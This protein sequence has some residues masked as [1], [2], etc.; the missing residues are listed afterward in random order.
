MPWQD[1][2]AFV[3]E[4]IHTGAS[5]VTRALLEFVILTAARSGEARAMAWDEVDL[6]AKVWTVPASRMKTKVTHRVPLPNRVVEILVAQ[7]KQHPE[8]ELVFPSPRGL[9]LCDMVLT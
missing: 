8:S 7:R 3:K 4:V 2:P 1:I 6:R 9:I 5:N